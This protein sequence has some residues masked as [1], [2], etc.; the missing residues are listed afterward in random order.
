MV[1]GRSSGVFTPSARLIAANTPLS[2]DAAYRCRHSVRVYRRRHQGRS[3]PGRV[4]GYNPTSSQENQQQLVAK[5]NPSL[6]LL[7]ESKTLSASSL[8]C[9]VSLSFFFPQH[10][11]PIRQNFRVLLMYRRFIRGKNLHT[12]IKAVKFSQ[13]T[14]WF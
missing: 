8:A 6:L 11:T 4:C 7:T 13:I 5:Q 9:L 10:G 1:D 12:A 14:F 2:L 3:R